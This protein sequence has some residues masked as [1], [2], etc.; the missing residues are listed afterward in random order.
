MGAVAVLR[1]DHPGVV[2][3]FW[4][5]EAAPCPAQTAP[6]AAGLVEE[7][8]REVVGVL[9]VEEVVLAV[10]G[11]A[12]HHWKTPLEQPCLQGH[13]LVDDQALPE[14]QA[15]DRAVQHAECHCGVEEVPLPLVDARQ[16]VGLVHVDERLPV[17]PVEVHVVHGVVAWPETQV[18][19][20][21]A[22][23]SC[24]LD[25]VQGDAVADGLAPP[26]E[27]SV[28]VWVQLLAWILLDGV[29]DA[30][31]PLDE[32]SVTV[33]VPQLA[34]ALPVVEAD[35]LAPPG[36]HSV[37]VLE[38]LLAWALRVVVADAPV[39]PDARWAI[40]LEQLLAWALP[41][42]EADEL[43]PQGEHSVIVLEQ[44]LAW[45]LPVVV[46]DAPV[47][48]DARWAIAWARPLAWVRLAAVEDGLARLDAHLELAW[49]PLSSGAD[50]PLE[51]YSQL[52]LD[53][54]AG[55]VHRVDVAHLVVAVHQAD[56]LRLGVEHP[57]EDVG[58]VADEDHQVDEVVAPLGDE[59][60]SVALDHP[61]DG[62]HEVIAGRPV[63]QLQG[64]HEVGV[65]FRRAG[66]EF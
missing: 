59:A 13:E 27:H 50:G 49:V 40:V 1:G 6:H 44:L 64:D 61:E 12:A 32:H 52:H 19:R 45:A 48:P 23:S 46:V 26:G 10:V 43:V 31:A 20:S 36:E 60:P 65:Q 3:Q 38:Q 57:S 17:F 14:L 7:V 37:N 39:P 29:G 63:S 16:V 56:V 53:R 11:A 33:W 47:P 41:V 5:L 18:A 55:A 42:V 15:A 58:R 54:Q 30:L 28:T 62:A 8:G 9:L 22:V 35:V 24:L 21:V 4:V 25:E 34:W 51:R 66:Q 2:A